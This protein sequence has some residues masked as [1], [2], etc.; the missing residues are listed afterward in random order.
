MASQTGQKIFDRTGIIATF[1]GK[2]YGIIAVQ[3]FSYALII[4]R[5]IKTSHF[6]PCKM[7]FAVEPNNKERPCFP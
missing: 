4:G 3:F 5:T 1:S 6:A 7:A 2:E